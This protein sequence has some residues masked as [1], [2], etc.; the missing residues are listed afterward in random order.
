VK[1][2]LIVLVYVSMVI[3]DGNFYKNSRD[4]WFFYETTV[5]NNI[6]KEKLENMSAK[7]LEAV[8]INLKDVAVSNP[9]KENVANYILAQNVAVKR[10]EQFATVW[11][12]VLLEKSELDIAAPLSKSGF[13]NNIK[14][15]QRTQ[16]NTQFWRE[17]VD[18]IGF[19]V[20]IDPKNKVANESIERVYFLLSEEIEHMTQKKPVIRFVDVVQNQELAKELGVVTTPDNFIIVN[21]NGTPSYKRI[22]AGV[23][24]KVELLDMV[25]FVID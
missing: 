25:R 2:L 6:T 20:L 5:E 1:A 15:V 8:I 22:K 19:I 23:A 17:N 10:S 24:T 3:A 9:T 13:E 21:E 18:K 11:Q 7:E 12:K 16:D 4:G 14:I